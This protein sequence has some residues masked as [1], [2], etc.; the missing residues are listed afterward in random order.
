MHGAL[1]EDREALEKWKELEVEFGDAETP[2]GSRPEKN[3]D[4]LIEAVDR[5]RGYD[6]LLTARERVFGDRAKASRR[7]AQPP[8]SPRPRAGVAAHGVVRTAVEG[9]RGGRRLV[10][11]GHGD[12]E[13]PRGRTAGSRAAPSV[14]TARTRER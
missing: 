9:P 1:S 10:S 5:R 2:E 8:R 6:R 3:V 7:R 12:V 14:S 4:L 11:A 13:G